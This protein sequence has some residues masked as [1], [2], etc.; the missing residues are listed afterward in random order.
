MSQAY[1]Q[2]FRA[3]EQGT[4]K[5]KRP[6]EPFDVDLSPE[7]KQQ[8]A[9]WLC[10]E[11]ENA[12]TARSSVIAPQG[13]IDY[14]NWAYEQ[15]RL[16]RE[17]KRFEGAADLASYILCEKVDSMRARM[18]KT[19]FVEP[20]WTVQGWGKDAAKAPLAEEFH[21]WKVEDER[22]QSYI[23]KAFHNALLEGNGILEVIERTDRR[24]VTERRDVAPKLND[25]GG[26]F[27][28][29][30]G[31][32]ELDMDDDGMP[33][34]AKE[35]EPVVETTVSAFKSMRQGP[36]YRVVSL[37]DFLYLPGHA[38]DKADLFGYAKRC[39]VRMGTL[40][41]RQAQG[42]YENVEQLSGES[43]RESAS[44]AVERAGQH[45][46]E[47]RE[48]TVE[49]ELWETL[50][51]YDCD[52]DG[53]EEWYL[54]TVH[55]PSKTL[56]R[57]KHDDLGHPRYLDFCPFPRT[58]SL[59]GYSYAGH[60]LMTLNEEHTAIRNMNADRSILAT[61]PPIKRLTGSLWDPV[62]QPWGT[63]A[64]IDV[65]AMN[66]VE[67]MVVPDLPASAVEREHA[68][69]AAAERVSGQNDIATGATSGEART[70][71]ERT[72]QAESSFVRVEE[73][74]KNCQETME[75]LFLV[76]NE[77]WR[78]TLQQ[79]GGIEPP[80]EV[81]RSIETRGLQTFQ[82][83]F[84]AEHLTGNLRGKPR[85]SVE[86]A[87]KNRMLFNF[88]ESV[89]ALAG[90]AQ[91]NPVFAAVLQHPEVAKSILEQWARLYSVQDRHVFV[92]AANAVIEGMKAQ[93]AAQ[94]QMQAEE[95][96]IMQGQLGPAGNAGGLPPGLLQA[97]P[98]EAAAI[99]GGGQP[100]GMA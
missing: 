93:A 89:K 67:A 38:A 13:E 59:Y 4:R 61:N 81:V 54:A 98:P 25:E 74:V 35:G 48:Q 43:D 72:M 57:L 99:L 47:Q 5:K 77:I 34:P 51:L 50:V 19:V 60:K 18:V 16:R 96:A 56:L 44:A 22:L 90:M 15:G 23:G 39:Y 88:N 78:R 100:E 91:M 24:K 27:L 94:Q 37:R 75:T 12:C 3:S 45:I 31:K 11:I 21:Q 58:D 33:K 55:V 20:V 83:E 71:G 17:D 40:H 53:I 32:P 10:Q 85:G 69:L 65:R 70:L 82:G 49:K 68:V 9:D 26:L 80:Q 95:Q 86:T 1:R 46:A 2:Q 52:G 8:F 64:V 62:E 6:K 30:D 7:E 76:R 14:V 36:G 87:D 66:E 28:G 97:L 73:P 41:E 79:T 92:Q 63:G 29:E 84:T 42:W